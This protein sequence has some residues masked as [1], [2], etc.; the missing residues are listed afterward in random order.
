MNDLPE[1]WSRAE[2]SEVLE[3]N[4]NGKPFQQGW[5][6]RCKNYSAPEG[7]WGVLKT[8]SIQYGK[9]WDHENKFLPDHLE[10]RPHL[11]VKFGDVLMTCAGPRARCGVACLVERTRSKLMMSGKMYRF[12]PHAKAIYPKYLAYYLQSS[13]SRLEIDRM[14]TGINDSGLN[15][16]HNRFA[17]LNVALAP[18]N[19]QRR[20]VAKIE[21]LFSELDKGIGSLKSARAKLNVYRQALLKD[22][23]EGKLT[24]QW[25]KVNKDKFEKPEQLLARIKQE[26]EARCKQQLKEW[27]T[28]VKAWEKRGKEGHKP[29]RPN[30]RPAL[31]FPSEVEITNL[32]LLTNGWLHIKAEALLAEPLANGH[33][34]KDRTSGFPVLRLTA[35][36]NEKLELSEAKNGNWERED[37]LPYLVR[38]GDFLIA[39]GNGS[40]QLVGRGCSVPALEHD[41]AFPDT[42][43]R[44]R[45]DTSVIN[46]SFFSYVWN[47]PLL[48]QQIEGA[49]R[50][51]AGIYKINQGQ[52]LNFIVP[53]CSLTEQTVVVKRLSVTLSVIDQIE[54]EIN[55]HFGRADSLRQTILKK[56][57]SGQ[58]VPQDPHDEPASVLLARIRAARDKSEKNRRSRKK[59]TTA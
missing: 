4:N 7:K 14:K 37:A 13:G 46:V 20:I 16:T 5:S 47:S 18:L 58:L 59:K 49:A 29:R 21:E 17:T 1:S 11:E 40:K 9:F 22:A 57:F 31:I 2:I 44:L 42:M 23:F 24:A 30:S 51:T 39:R 25:R 41:V 48:R 55:K 34:V 56:A 27:R 32:P 53:L 45:V 12:R 54:K 26:R 28:A 38:E 19:E 50:T 33:S 43:I 52:I 15:L 10:P 6:P 35:I 36:K 3:A 8:T